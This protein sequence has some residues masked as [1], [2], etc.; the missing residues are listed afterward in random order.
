MFRYTGVGL[1]RLND[2]V[3]YATATL[4][5]YIRRFCIQKSSFACSVCRL[6]PGWFVYCSKCATK[7]DTNIDTEA[8][9]LVW[10]SSKVS[11]NPVL[12]SKA[13]TTPQRSNRFLL[14][15]Y[16]QSCLWYLLL[17]R[18][19]LS[20]FCLSSVLRTSSLPSRPSLSR[21]P[22]HMNTSPLLIGRRFWSS[23]FLRTLLRTAS[24]RL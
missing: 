17:S 15:K 24:A 2:H 12:H 21:I 10:F 7:V 3:T 4:V 23:N 9:V 6:K 19:L 5:L 20:T 8:L 16:T 13:A 22:R 14:Y 11:L 1:A 18:I